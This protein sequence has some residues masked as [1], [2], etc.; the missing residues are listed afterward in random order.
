MPLSAQTTGQHVS[1]G[2]SQLA[3]MTDQGLIDAHAS[4]SSAINLEPE[5]GEARFLRAICE[6]LLAET[7]VQ[8][9]DMLASFGSFK[10]GPL[11]GEGTIDSNKDWLGNT[12]YPNG[13]NSSTAVDWVKQRLQPRLAAARAD[14]SHITDNSFSTT[15]SEQELGA[16]ISV[17]RGDALALIASLHGV[18]LFFEF[19]F[20]YDLGIPM[21]SVA[22]LNATGE[23]DAQHVLASSSSLLNFASSDRRPAFA[24]ALR[25]LDASYATASDFFQNHRD[26]PNS[27]PPMTEPLFSSLGGDKL[28]GYL[29]KS[30]ESLDGEVVVDGNRLDLSRHLSSAV[31]LRSWLPA[32]RN[33]AA[34]IGTLPDPTFGGVLPD[35]TASQVESRIS[36]LSGLWGMSQYSQDMGDFLSFMG[37]DGSPTGDADGDGQSNFMEYVLGSDLISRNPVA[38]TFSTSST[39]PGNPKEVRLSF[40]RRKSLEDWEVIVS[41]S[42]D[43]A[44]WEKTLAEAEMVGSPVDNGDGFTETV[45]FRL[46]NSAATANRK[47]LRIEPVPR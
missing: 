46:K 38:Q 15:V 41:T 27:P 4:F 39:G 45:V 40:S 44:H 17:D 23:L 36:Q 34:V 47:F 1:S 42:D 22:Q 32:F 5:N 16:E 35:S 13:S 8:F 43:M 26:T 31:P 20:T 10:T 14:L 12:I 19:I 21:Q 6:L 30:A 24:Q 11:R 28:G 29:Q 2:R 7:E 37:M 18:E 9:D 3:L 33:K 25:S